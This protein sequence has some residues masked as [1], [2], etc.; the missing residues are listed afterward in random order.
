MITEEAKDIPG[1]IFVWVT[2]GQGWKS[3]RKNLFETFEVLPTLYNINDLKQ[4]VLNQWK[5]N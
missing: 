1:V 4:G 3:A 2:D 5:A